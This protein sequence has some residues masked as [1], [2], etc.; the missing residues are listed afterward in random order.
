[1]E[2]EEVQEEEE[3]KKG[4]GSTY[5]KLHTALAVLVFTSSIQ[6]TTFKFLPLV[7]SY[8]LFLHSFLCIYVVKSV[9]ASVSLGRITMTWRL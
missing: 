8:N 1:M 9:G 7:E 4:G 3:E 6:R 5:S 2:E